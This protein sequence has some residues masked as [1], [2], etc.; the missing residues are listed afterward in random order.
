MTNIK[1]YQSVDY[2]PFEGEEYPLW[3]PVTEPQKEIWFSTLLGDDANC[4]FNECIGLYL[5][6]KLDLV[7]LERAIEKTFLRHDALR[8]Y[9]DLDGEK[10][11][12]SSSLTV[13]INHLDFSQIDEH[14]QQLK[15]EEFLQ[16]CVQIPFDLTVFPLYRIY[17]VRL[18]ESRHL[19][20]INIHHI[21]CDGWSLGV[22]IKDISLFYNSFVSNR[23][24]KPDPAPQFYH[25][26]YESEKFLQSEKFLE[27][28]QY[29]VNQFKDNIPFVELPVEKKRPSVR[30]FKGNRYDKPLTAELYDLLKKT[31]AKYQISFVSLMLSLFEAYILRITGQ[32]ELITG[33]PVASQPTMGYDDLVGHCVNLLP[34]KCKHSDQRFSDFIQER[35]RYL[36]DAL[37]HQQITFGRLVNKLKIDRNLSRIPL[38]AVVFNADI[39]LDKGVVFEGLEHILVSNPRKAEN[40]ELFLNITGNDEQA[41][42]EFSYNISLFSLQRIKQIAEEFIVFC[43]SACTDPL[44]PVDTINLLPDW[45]KELLTQKWC[46]RSS[47]YPAE[48]TVHEIFE[49]IA[50]N[51]S[52]KPALIFREKY[53]TYRE[54]DE[55]ANCLANFL[56]DLGITRGSKIAVCLPSSIEMIISCIAILKTGSCYVPVPL[57]YPDFRQEFIIRKAELNVI[58]KNSHYQPEYLKNIDFLEINIDQADI[59]TS[60]NKAKP[61]IDIDSTSLA[62]IMFTSGSTGEPKG[63]GIP[64]KGIVRLVKNNDYIDFTPDLIFLQLSNIGFDAS[65]FEIWGSL[66]NGAQLVLMPESHSNLSD[67]S[68]VIIK[69]KINVLWLTSGL[70]SLMVN[71]QPE[72]LVGLKYLLAGGDVLS[73]PHV[74]KALGSLG[75]GKLINGYGPTENTTFTTTYTINDAN[76]IL[77][78]VPIGR[79]ICNTIVYVL[80]SKLNPVPIG[81]NGELYCGGDGLAIGYVNN[82]ELTEQKFIINPFSADKNSKLYRTGDIVNWRDDGNLEFIGRSDNQIKIRGFRLE[83]NEIEKNLALY[84]GTL[85]CAVIV[86]GSDAINKQIIAYVVFK[87]ETATVE[88]LYDFLS[89]RLPDFMIPSGIVVLKELPINE[90]GKVDKNQLTNKINNLPEHKDI[91]LP[92]SDVEKSLL[93]IWKKYLGL[94]QISVKDN[95]FHIGGHSLIAVQILAEIENEYHIRLPLSVFFENYTIR[96]LSKIVALKAESITWESLVPIKIKGDKIPLFI[97]HGAGMNVVL[98]EALGKRMSPDQPVYA[99]Q[100]RGLDGKSDPFQNI[101]DMASFYISEIFKVRHEGPIALAGY[102]MGGYIAFEMAQQLSKMDRKPAFLGMFDTDAYIHKFYQLNENDNLLQ[103]TLFIIYQYLSRFLFL[104]FLFIK[105][106]VLFLVEKTRVMKQKINFLLYRFRSR[107]QNHSKTSSILEKVEA[108]GF[109]ALQRYQL[110]EYDGDLYLFKAKNQTFYIPDRKYYGWKKYIKGQIYDYVIPGKH[111]DMF[112]PPND[113]EFAEILQKCLDEVNEKHSHEKEI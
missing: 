61:A 55:K 81:V 95:F 9:F 91:V 46:C 60:G 109:L 111:S 14:H 49:E 45:E 17:L 108:A 31:S 110:K 104:F 100:A 2:N 34:I 73:V 84:P 93:K 22:L 74:L 5:I 89:E 106:P 58:L 68:E 40:F 10:M 112:S 54:L 88:D 80:D 47:D 70:F 67:I 103:K 7:S 77:K 36:I 23:E 113:L 75:P 43:T 4:A 71:H 24:F 16:E 62:Y 20:I 90:Q 101:E 63:V 26:A 69:Y 83:L 52:E 30:T 8:G 56:I 39:G 29:W 50:E 41:V 86:K 76:Q 57:D 107:N 87:D 13:S 85:D 94:D 79:P 25:F 66:L 38:I 97:V 96:S 102:S 99:L 64:H 27:I 12:F 53:L 33:L 65:T 42:L 3:C 82:P 51:Y 21:I 11:F 1:E 98:F 92:V 15:I 28:E 35:K 105:N 6:G 32:E 48:K 72:C 78:S 59:F 18:N 37:D 44:Q 19:L